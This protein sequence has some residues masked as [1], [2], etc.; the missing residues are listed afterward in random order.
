M[1][2]IKGYEEKC[3]FNPSLHVCNLLSSPKSQLHYKSPKQTYLLISSFTRSHQVHKN[4]EQ[5]F[6]KT[7]TDG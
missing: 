6:L 3:G 5:A 2:G 7:Y 1:L 4:L